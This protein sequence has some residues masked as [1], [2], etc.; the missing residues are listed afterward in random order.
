MRFVPTGISGAGVNLMQAIA[1]WRAN[2]EA[3]GE[4]ITRLGL[5]LLMD[6]K[7]RDQD[8]QAEDRR[9]QLRSVREEKNKRWEYRKAL[10]LENLT[11][12]R[13][14]ARKL[15][16]WEHEERVEKIK[17]GARSSD[18]AASPA[19]VRGQVESMLGRNALPETSVKTRQDQ[20]AARERV[21]VVDSLY[22][23][24]GAGKD[25]VKR[26][27]A[28]RQDIIDHPE[29]YPEQGKMAG[30]LSRYPDQAPSRSAT[31]GFTGYNPVTL[32][33]ALGDSINQADFTKPLIN[34]IYQQGATDSS[35]PVYAGVIQ[36]EINGQN[37]VLQSDPYK[38]AVEYLVNTGADPL[39]AA[40]LVQR[41]GI[42][43]TVKL[44][45][46]DIRAR[47]TQ[48]SGTM[49]AEQYSKMADALEEENKKLE[50]MT[51]PGRWGMKRYGEMKT[52]MPVW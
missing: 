23:K 16:E 25:E 47:A 18:K 13:E 2:Q 41:R 42:K 51:E 22:P 37:Q 20:E 28:L 11:Q 31:Y 48:A 27:A 39:Q 5:P 49:T 9:E 50:V 34:Q 44:I 35:L 30:L 17:A 19:E 24:A 45:K 4:L 1:S 7:Q 6:M 12:D 21:G 10:D 36:D 43:E 8:R 38:S 15:K 52:E 29:Q 26:L 33:T 14:D 40:M 46:E 3:Q 32:A